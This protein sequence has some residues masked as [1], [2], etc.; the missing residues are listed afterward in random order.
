MNSIQEAIARAYEIGAPYSSAVI[1]IYLLPGTHFMSRQYPTDFYMPQKY[2]QNS[3]TTKIILDAYD[4]W[5]EMV[6][7]YKLRDSFKFYVG[8]GLTIHNIRF[9]AIDSSLDLV[10]DISSGVNYARRTNAN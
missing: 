3:Q 10:T 1:S 4:S 2:D 6:V 9:N 5:T 7:N 8:A